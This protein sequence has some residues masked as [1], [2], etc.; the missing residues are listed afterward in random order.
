MKIFG[1]QINGSLGL[2]KT[3]ASRKDE[4]AREWVPQPRLIPP[5]E[6]AAEEESKKYSTVEEIREA[7]RIV[8]G[9]IEAIRGQMNAKYMLKGFLM[10]RMKQATL[11]EG[12]L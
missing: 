2:S 10:A 8:E 3:A 12:K 5:E 9:E 4:Q 7:I 11:G 6:I 1:N